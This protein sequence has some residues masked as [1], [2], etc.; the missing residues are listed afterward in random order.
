ML[1]W[2]L[3]IALVGALL[4]SFYQDWKYRAISWMVFPLTLFI[5]GGI[6]YTMDIPLNVLWNNLAFLVVVIGMLFVYVSVKR[7]QLT[8]IF[9]ADFGLG[10]VL[11]LL[12][13]IPLFGVQ[14]YILFFITG[15]LFSGIVHFIIYAINGNQKIP[16]AGY[17][18]LYI[19]GLK[20]ADYFVFNNL[21][22]SP[23]LG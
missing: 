16:L 5:A 9:R 19:I 17:L 22:Y 20:G 13:V 11:F 12:A 18:A 8:N 7:G 23:V 10:D 14:N 3:H 15:M 1:S 2:I 21:F 6:F 4:V